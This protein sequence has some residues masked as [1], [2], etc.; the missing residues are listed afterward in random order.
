VS[1]QAE[2]T[3]REQLTGILIRPNGVQYFVADALIYSDILKQL[4]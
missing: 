4:T 1:N 3:L 2:I